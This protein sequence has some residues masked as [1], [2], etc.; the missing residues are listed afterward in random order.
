MTLGL[1]CPRTAALGRACSEVVLRLCPALSSPRPPQCS[2]LRSPGPRTQHQLHHSLSSGRRTAAPWPCW[3]AAV[4]SWGCRSVRA[5]CLPGQAAQPG[6][7]RARHLQAGCWVGLSSSQDA[8][9]LR[10]LVWIAATP[11]CVQL[12]RQVSFPLQY[13]L[14]STPQSVYAGCGEEVWL[15]G[16]CSLRRGN[17]GLLLAALPTAVRAHYS[18]L[19]A[20]E[21]FISLTSENTFHRFLYVY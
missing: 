4:G 3:G 18:L 15:G 16:C 2:G 11:N 12:G 7:A 10:Q 1:V 21:P 19:S 9:L 14:P 5:S 20:G 13:T 8:A 6:A 17:S